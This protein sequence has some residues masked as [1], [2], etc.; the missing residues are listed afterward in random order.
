MG[1]RI[2]DMRAHELVEFDDEHDDTVEI[3]N[4][5]KKAG[6]KRLGSGVDATVWAKDTGHVIKILMPNNKIQFKG[7]EKGFITFYDFCQSN[8]NVPYLPKFVNIGGKHHT[9]FILNGNA[10]R[11]IAM[12][13]LRKIRMDSFEEGMIWMLS[14]YA[15]SNLSW[16]QV[17]DEMCIAETWKFSRRFMKVMPPRINQLKNDPAFNKTYG[18]LHTLMQLLH[19]LATLKGLYWDLHTENVMQRGDGTLVITDPFVS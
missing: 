14:D 9:V 2:T 15:S 4:K 10:Y 17:R 3:I 13:K 8:S 19:R 6:Y 11:Q 12:E 16:E 5:L 1:Q 7:A 18:E